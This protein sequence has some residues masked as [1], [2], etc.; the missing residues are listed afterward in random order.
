LNSAG[1]V[2]TY[3]REFEGVDLAF[4]DALRGATPG[5][6]EN[7]SKIREC[8]DNLSRASEKTG[9]CFVVIHHAGKPKEGHSDAR[10]V[11]R[12][13]S[14]IFDACGSVFVMTGQ[15]SPAEAEGGAVEDFYLAIE[16]VPLEDDPRAGVRVV[17]QTKEEVDPPV[18]PTV[19][20]E[21]K[22]G[23]VL[24]C[25]RQNPGVPGV[26]RIAEMIA[27]RPATVRQAIGAL[28]EANR[29]TD[30]GTA[31]PAR[32]RLFAMEVPDGRDG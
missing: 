14:A 7:D 6:D 24:E 13:S 27:M 12:G 16:D 23:R 5:H 1:A 19:M 25:I 3:A 31:K 15:K 10:T 17:Y 2:D 22:V 28:L 29:I 20:F 26:E 30:R 8:L 18:K 9:T 11:A 32:P 4:V 21:E